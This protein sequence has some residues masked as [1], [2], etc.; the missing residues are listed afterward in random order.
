MGIIR[1]HHQLRTFGKAGH[2]VRVLEMQVRIDLLEDAVSVGQTDDNQ[3]AVAVGGC[4]EILRADDFQQAIGRAARAEHRHDAP[5]ERQFRLRRVIAEDHHNVV[6]AACAL[7]RRRQI[8][9]IQRC[10]FARRQ[11]Q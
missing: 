10:V 1:R 4:L 7:E 9:Q 8:C 6:H 3:V 11:V 5:R 2:I